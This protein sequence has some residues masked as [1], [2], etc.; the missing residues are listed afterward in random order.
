VSAVGISRRP[1]YS[2]GMRSDQE[3]VAA[4]NQSYVGSYRTLIKH[5]PDGKVIDLDGVF[6]FATGLP[7]ALFNGCVVVEP[8]PADQL[9]AAIHWIA[10][11]GVPHRVWIADSVVPYLGHVPLAHGLRVQDRPYP[12]MVL[13]PVPEP[14]RPA[15]GVKVDTVAPS[16]LE[17]FLQVSIDAGMP[18]DP[19]RQLFSPSFAADPDV[20]LF[21]GSL[22]GRPVGTAV[23]IRTGDVSGVYAVGTLPAARRRGLGSALTWAAVEAGHAWGCDTTVLQASEMGLPIYEAMGFRTVVDYMVYSRPPAVPSE[24]D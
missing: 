10:D 21:I 6:A 4:A 7:L 23:A 9:D 18:P 1:E 15:A 22:D 24:V 5:C 16:D 14:P 11:R 17:R 2:G 19:A 20:R 8:A 12:G 3:L 13:H